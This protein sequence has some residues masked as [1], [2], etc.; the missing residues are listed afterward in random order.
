[1]I[2]CCRR[3]FQYP[4]SATLAP[5]P[6]CRNYPQAALGAAR[7]EDHIREAG[8]LRAVRAGVWEHSQPMNISVSS[9]ARRPIFRAF[10]SILFGH[11][12]RYFL[13]V[14]T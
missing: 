5:A 3:A 10:V 13:Q 6:D 14:M 7:G 2:I 4:P 8:V 9:G 12:G 1:M 11:L